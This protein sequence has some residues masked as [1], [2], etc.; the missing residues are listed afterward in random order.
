MWLHNISNNKTKKFPNSSLLS[1]LP[2]AF[3]FCFHSSSFESWNQQFNTYSANGLVHNSIGRT[4]TNCNSQK[5]DSLL[6][7]HSCIS[8]QILNLPLRLTL[9]WTYMPW[10]TIVSTFNTFIITDGLD[11]SNKHFIW[12]TYNNSCCENW[13]Q[14]MNNITPSAS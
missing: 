4:E 11:A 6:Q 1:F 5:K 13:W 9:S 3:S 12:L 14:Q 2:G 8:C 10:K 7:W